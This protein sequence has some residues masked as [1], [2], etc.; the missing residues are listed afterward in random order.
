[1]ANDWDSDGVIDLTGVSGEGGSDVQE[2]DE[3]GEK[4]RTKR[5]EI[6][7][8]LGNNARKRRALR[9]KEDNEDHHLLHGN[10]LNGEGSAGEAG[11][12]VSQVFVTS[13]NSRPSDT[14]SGHPV[15][16]QGCRLGAHPRQWRR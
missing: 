12:D 14:W 6:A 1:M 16:F 9:K 8:A 10:V 2:E 3:D 15:R 5:T 4:T 13:R 7:V 11:H